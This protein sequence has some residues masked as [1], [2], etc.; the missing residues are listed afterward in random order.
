MVCCS[1]AFRRPHPLCLV[2]VCVCVCVFR[3]SVF[4]AGTV[5]AA[6]PP[7][8]VLPVGNTLLKL[9][10]ISG[11]EAKHHTLRIRRV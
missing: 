5:A 8:Q 10:F 9:R 6:G 1:L 7:C 2:Y 11:D 4:V 3:V